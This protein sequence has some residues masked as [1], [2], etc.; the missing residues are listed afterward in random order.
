MSETNPNAKSPAVA[1][2]LWFFVGGVGAHRF[3]MGRVGS[4]IGMMALAIASLILSFFLIGLI[5]YPI[6][7]VWWVVDAFLINR[8]LQESRTETAGT[9]VAGSI[10]ESPA[11]ERDA[12]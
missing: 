3:Y 1:Y 9:P 11:T 2:L 6:L 8:W 7:F 12:A 4:G 5:G 10:S